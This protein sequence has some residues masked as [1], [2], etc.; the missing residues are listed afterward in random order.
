MQLVLQLLALAYQLR[1]LGLEH[2]VLVQQV[3]LCL[4]G[5][6]H[7]VLINIIL[8]TLHYIDHLEITLLLIV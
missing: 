8:Q 6:V 1:I 4:F 3:C 5:H 2:L 7:Y